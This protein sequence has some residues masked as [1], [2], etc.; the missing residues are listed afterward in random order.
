MKTYCSP[1]IW[2]I[3]FKTWNSHPKHKS[4][5]YEMLWKWCTINTSR[6]FPT[7][8]GKCRQLC[9]CLHST[10]E[11]GPWWYFLWSD[12]E[13]WTAQPQESCNVPTQLVF[14]KFFTGKSTGTWSKP[15]KQEEIRTKVKRH[16][17]RNDSVC[18]YCWVIHWMWNLTS[19]WAFRERG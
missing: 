6:E 3:M 16:G 9:F 15:R 2:Q 8:E 11:K 14:W 10:K 4:L 19:L 7:K 5:K 1:H 17:R 18:P 12:A 13:Q